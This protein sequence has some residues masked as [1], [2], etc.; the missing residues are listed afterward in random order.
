MGR[1]NAR[2]PPT[3]ANAPK[4]KN[5]ERNPSMSAATKPANRYEKLKVTV[6]I[7]R[8]PDSRFVNMSLTVWPNVKSSEECLVPLNL[9]PD[10]E[11]WIAS[12]LRVPPKEN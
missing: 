9:I 2:K 7:G 1:T 3:R 12:D 10:A 5:A 11:T 4:R 8:R 6:R